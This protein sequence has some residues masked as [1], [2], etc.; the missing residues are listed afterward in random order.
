VWWSDTPETPEP[1]GVAGIRVLVADDDEGVRSLFAALLHQAAGVSAV[2][3]VDDGADAVRVVQEAGV[4]VAVLDLNMP[5]IDGLKAALKLAALQ[6]S[7]G[8]ALHSS[9]LRALR[10]RASGLGIPL[11]DKYAF[12]SLVAWVERQASFLSAADGRARANVL[13]LARKLDLTCSLCGYGIVSRAPPAHCPMCQAV[14]VWTEQSGRL[15]RNAAG[16]ERFGD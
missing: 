6:P 2:L 1:R 14:A 15:A 4:Q 3:E 10:E 12:G 13:P 9:D 7:I 5:R 11:F 16:R 8:L